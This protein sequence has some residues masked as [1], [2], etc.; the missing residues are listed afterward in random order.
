MLSRL[1]RRKKHESTVL[2]ANSWR[3]EFLRTSPA[4]FPVVGG[5]RLTH[6]MNHI[7]I[8][9]IVLQNLHSQT[10]VRHSFLKPSRHIFYENVINSAGILAIATF[11]NVIYRCVRSPNRVL[12]TFIGRSI[13]IVFQYGP[14][15][16]L[17]FRR[18]SDRKFWK[19]LLEGWEWN[20]NT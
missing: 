20:R 12:I 3:S 16:D 1:M 8:R 5:A 7:I 18:K 4:Q 15:D 6:K 2:L 19:N 17:H 9:V 14:A 10:D 11:W 13:N